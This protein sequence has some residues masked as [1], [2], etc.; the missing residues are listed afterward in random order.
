MSLIPTSDGLRDRDAIPNEPVEHASNP[1]ARFRIDDDQV[2]KLVAAGDRPRNLLPRVAECERPLHT[3]A[4]QRLMRSADV[5]GG[6]LY[7]ELV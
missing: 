4:K 2:R 1:H 5:D 6:A 3:A 7:H